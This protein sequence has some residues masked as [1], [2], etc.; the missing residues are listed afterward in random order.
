MTIPTHI[1]HA[2]HRLD[3]P[4]CGYLY[5]LTT[6]TE[7]I[8]AVTQAL[9]A[10]VQ[11][12]YAMKAN[13]HPDIVATAAR[14]CHGIEIA[15]GGEL[16]I[17]QAADPDRLIF[18]GPAKTDRELHAALHAGIPTTINVESRHE[19]RRLDRLAHAEDVTID[20]AL[21]V[22][23]RAATPHGS[24]KM[25]G[26]ATPF[27]IDITQLPQAIALAKSLPH[28]RL[29]GLHLHAVSNNLHADAHADYIR[30]CLRFARATARRHGLTWDTI[31]VGG[32]IGVDMTGRRQFDFPRFADRLRRF[33]TTGLVIEPG[34]YLA[35][36]CGWYAA[37]VLDLKRNHGRN[38][39]VLRGG[40][41]HF[42]LPA[43]WGYHHPAYVHHVDEWPYPWPRAELTHT[44]VDVA[45][46]LCTPRDIL[47]RD[48][49]VTRLRI[50]DVLVFPHTGAYG[51]TISHHDFLSH[52]HPQIIT[53]SGR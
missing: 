9:P 26:T 7:H 4:R 1:S 2:I 44:T 20:I 49:P 30:D 27:G 12:L 39:A 42:R 31:N 37:E 21:R 15:S 47:S 8:T 3:T 36:G 38:F 18:G 17:A 28:I 33:D 16:A 29:R 32:G 51:W 40:T 19:L 11:L 25:T 23:R 50:G 48:V 24:H 35:A 34:R 10:N 52:P 46:E 41:H 53:I 22:N 45:G 14:H 13:P 5:D 6:L 43:A